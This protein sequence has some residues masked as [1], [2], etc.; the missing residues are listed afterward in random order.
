MG[1]QSVGKTA[2][3]I[4]VYGGPGAAPNAWVSGRAGVGRGSTQSGAT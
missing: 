1:V 3:Q 2:K 4:S